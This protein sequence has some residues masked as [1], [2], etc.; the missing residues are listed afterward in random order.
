MFHPKPQP[1]CKTNINYSVIPHQNSNISPIFTIN[2]VAFKTPNNPATGQTVNSVVS[3]VARFRRP[4]FGKL[5]SPTAPRAKTAN[6]SG[7]K[8]FSISTP[9]PHC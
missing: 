9:Q 6:Q 7:K 3:D 5:I 1:L 4:N 2:Y 8:R